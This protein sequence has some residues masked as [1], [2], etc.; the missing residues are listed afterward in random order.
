MAPSCQFNLK[1]GD[2]GRENSNFRSCI[3]S[4]KG[5]CKS[6][7]R[8]WIN[9]PSLIFQSLLVPFLHAV[10]FNESV[11]F[12]L[13]FILRLYLISFLCFLFTKIRINE[14]LELGQKK[15]EFRIIWY[16]RIY[17]NELREDWNGILD[18]YSG[19]WWILMIY[20][21]C[22]NDKRRGN[23]IRWKISWPS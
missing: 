8:D 21:N 3:P 7:S 6:A 17:L 23:F 9:Y 20:F 14:Y 2:S 22:R 19:T 18:N 16:E 15:G 4:Q 13:S 11:R 12:H 10:E 1:I 5:G